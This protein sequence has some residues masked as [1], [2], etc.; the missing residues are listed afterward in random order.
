[1]DVLNDDNQRISGT[2]LTVTVG[3]EIRRDHFRISRARMSGGIGRLYL[4]GSR[5]IE[6]RRKLVNESLR[7]QLAM[8]HC[9]RFA[10]S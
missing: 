7:R 3:L 8:S 4:L 5:R 1:V 10:M 2:E 9:G 6:L